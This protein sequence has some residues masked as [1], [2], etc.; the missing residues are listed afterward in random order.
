MT[1]RKL[2]KRNLILLGMVLILV[3][4]PSLRTPGFDPDSLN[5]LFSFQNYSGIMSSDFVQ[6]EPMFYFLLEIN[7]YTFNNIHGLFFLFAML[8]IA[9]LMYAFSKYKLNIYLGFLI[10][11]GFLYILYAFVQIRVGVSISIFILS[12]DDLVKKKRS[13]YL[14]KIFIAMLF[15][16]SA[17]VFLLFVFINPFQKNPWFYMLLPLFAALIGKIVDINSLIIFITT[18]VS[19]LMNHKLLNATLLYDSGYFQPLYYLSGYIISKVVIYYVVYFSF[20]KSKNVLAVLS[21]KIYAWSLF[22]MFSLSSFSLFAVRLSDMISSVL[23]ILL[24]LLP[25]IYKQDNL[26]RSLIILFSLISLLFSVTQYLRI[27]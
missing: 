18:S 7:K 12:L 19:F 11:I 17:V 20:K 4:L 9:I 1:T 10:Y 23:I 8:Q 13:N 21:V 27:N 6:H 16:Y 2:K 24:L 3:V 22:V 14:L 5:Y 25:T 26:I 15:H